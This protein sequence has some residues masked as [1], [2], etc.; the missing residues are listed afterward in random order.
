MQ[1]AIQY[2]QAVVRA[3]DEIA[4]ADNSNEVVEVAYFD[5]EYPD[6]DSEQQPQQSE[7]QQEQ[8]TEISGIL[9]ARRA[10]KAAQ[11]QQPTEEVVTTEQQPL[12][13]Q[14]QAALQAEIDE[15]KADT[16]F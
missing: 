16:L 6:N 5:T 11:Q 9:A 1:N 8:T 4:Q 13:Q 7:T 12:S 14:G 3:N 15:T 2:D 10:K